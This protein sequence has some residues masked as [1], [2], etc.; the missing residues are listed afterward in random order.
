MNIC[1][2]LRQSWTNKMCKVFFYP[3]YESN[4]IPKHSVCYYS[5]QINE[6]YN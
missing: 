1:S 5:N 6:I 3:L 4:I 2:N